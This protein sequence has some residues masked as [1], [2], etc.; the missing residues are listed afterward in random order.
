MLNAVI[1]AQA[2][3]LAT[4]ATHTRV[5]YSPICLPSSQDITEALPSFLQ[6]LLRMWEQRP[7]HMR[8]TQFDLHGPGWEFEVGELSSLL[9]DF[10]DR[11][12]VSKTDLGHCTTLPVEMNVPPGTTPVSLPAYRTNPMRTLMPFSATISRPDYCTS[13]R[14]GPLR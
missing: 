6:K 11:F 13:I 7:P 3:P 5:H 2:T 8:L 1:S 4:W 14:R 10:Q 12:S 9:L